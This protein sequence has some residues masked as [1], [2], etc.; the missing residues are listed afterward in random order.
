MAN[1][2]IFPNDKGGWSNDKQGTSSASVRG[3]VKSGTKLSSSS[4]NCVKSSASGGGIDFSKLYNASKS[5]NISGGFADS[6]GLNVNSIKSLG[7]IQG[8]D[9]KIKSLANLNNIK[10]QLKIGSVDG[11]E[12]LVTGS[13]TKNLASST[14][15]FG[16]LS[17]K[18]NNLTNNLSGIVSSTFN[19]AQKTIQSATSTVNKRVTSAVDSATSALNK[20]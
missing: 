19:N 4:T 10:S 3:S 12:K 15:A 20:K 5:G 13:L 17:S 14:N 7:N 9:S 16:A 2:N 11:I 18:I 8:I 6:V 1:F